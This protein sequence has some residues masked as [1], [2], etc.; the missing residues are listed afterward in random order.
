MMT[1]RGVWFMAVEEIT[2]SSA[3][4]HFSS[5]EVWAQLL[6]PKVM[7]V[8]E[9]PREKSIVQGKE[10]HVL[11]LDKQKGKSSSNLFTKRKEEKKER[12]RLVEWLKQKSICLVCVSS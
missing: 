12:E 8:P 6:K 10:S 7:N 11:G 1:G 9:F 2:L 4:D 5:E 3:G